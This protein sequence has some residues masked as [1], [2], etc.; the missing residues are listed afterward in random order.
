MLSAFRNSRSKIFYLFLF[1]LTG[2]NLLQAG[3]TSLNNDEAYYWMYSNYLDWGYFDHPPM[4][5]LMIKA[6]Y[7]IFHNELGVR[8]LVILCMA[9]SLMIILSFIDK[10]ARWKNDNILYFFILILILP[11]FNIYGFIATPDS[12]L[13]FFSVLFLFAYKRFLNNDTWKN[14]ILT[15]IAMAAL[16][17]S[18]YHAALIIILVIMS[19]LSLLKNKRFYLAAILA[20]LLYV[21]HIYWQFINDFP[22]FKYH[23][24][25]RV[26]GLDF[27]NIPEYL[28]NTLI[29]HNPVILPLSIWLFAKCRPAD[30]FERALW[31][32]FFGFLIFFF[33]ASF[34]YNVQPQW[35]V[36]IAIPMIII[37]FRN[38]DFYPAIRKTIKWVTLIMLPI[39]IIGRAALIF[40]FLPVAFLRDEFHDYEKRVKEISQLA[41]D[42]P[43]V[44]TNSYQDPSVYTFY[45]GKFAHSL[46]NLNYRRTQYDLWDFEEKLH[47]KE[48]LYVPHWPTTFIRNNFEKH[49]FFNGDSLYLKGYT[50][51]QSLQKECVILKDEQY[52]FRKNGSN[53][54]HLDIFNPYPYVIDIKHKEFPVVFQIGFFR[55]GL[56]EERWNLD[57]PDSVSQ[58]YPGDTIA[59][60]CQFNL[61]QLSYTAYRIVIC[62]E[63]GVLYDTFNSRFRKATVTE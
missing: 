38:I 10:D 48:V 45:T 37:L 31:F 29:F 41:G 16:M 62:S 25:E 20:V 55:D 9:A 60:D 53:T 51:F 30:K 6:G 7:S 57:L 21:P 8:L 59:I 52:S 26:S 27:G 58:L 12:P 32:V 5:A 22:S 17:Y 49:T 56:R 18:K 3:L 42:R 24:V 33:I 1:I 19:N 50:N 13:I 61:G 35:T 47:G 54:I 34:R 40:D 39:L 2:I 4:I 36:L 11:V 28:G 44:F 46:N 14:T 15:G 43:V 63:T 23:L